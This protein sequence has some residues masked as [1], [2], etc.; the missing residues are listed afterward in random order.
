[1]RLFCEDVA[2]DGGERGVVEKLNEN[3]DKGK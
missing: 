2:G 1:M 3:F